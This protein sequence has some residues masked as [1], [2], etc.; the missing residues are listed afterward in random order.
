MMLYC[1]YVHS[2]SEREIT[3]F[4]FVVVVVVERLFFFDGIAVNNQQLSMCLYATRR[5][6]PMN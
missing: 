5:Y 6:F 4:L 2:F 1:Y 3:F